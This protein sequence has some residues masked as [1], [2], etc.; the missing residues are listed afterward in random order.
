MYRTGDL[1]RYR[2]DGNIEFLGR[3]DHQVKVRGFRIELG[4]IEAQ[5]VDHAAVREAVVIARARSEASQ[6]Q[7]LIAYVTLLADVDASVLREH[8]AERLPDYMVP[9]A[10]VMLDALPLTPNGKLDRHALPD[11]HADAFALRPFEAPLGETES[12][13]ADLWAELLGLDR[14]GRQDNFFALGG[15]SLLAVTLI[16]RMRRIGLHANV[17]D[18][19]ATPVLS[20]L[21]AS[22]ERGAIPD[23]IVVPPNVIT[24]D[25]TALTPAMLP[26]IALTQADIDHIVGQVPGGLANVQDIYALA[27][28]QEGI[29]FHH[30]LTTEGDPYLQTARIAFDSRARLD[31]WLDALQRIIARHDILRTAFIHDGISTPAQV[32]CREAPVTI[33]EIEL[34]P[35]HGPAAD[36]LARLF[37]AR[38]QRLPLHQAPLLRLTIAKEHD[39]PRWLALLVWHHL[40]GDHVTLEVIQKEISALLEGRADALN[41]AQPFRD[42]V[43]QARLGATQQEHEAFFR[44]MLA[45]VSEPTLPFGF[46]DVHHDGSAVAEARVTLPAALNTRLRTQARELGVSLAS[47]CHLAW[48]RVLDAA[49]ASDGRIVFGTVLLGRMQA[50]VDQ[51]LGLLI[52]T[53]PIRL[54]VNDA[55]VVD[56]VRDTHRRL[57]ALLQHQHAPLALA[58]RCSGV[59]APAPLFSA[60]LNYRHNQAVA[61]EQY[62]FE[63]IELLGAEERTNYPLMLAVED[64]GE[65]LGL[66]AQ[67]LAPLSPDQLCGYMEQA[68]SSLVQALEQAPQTPVD[69]L[70]VLP[71]DTRQLLVQTWNDTAA[72]YPVELCIHQLF[73]QQ[74]ERTPDAIALVFDDQTLTYA[75]LNARANRLARRLLALGVE[76]EDRVALCVERG[77]G[78]VVSLLAILKAGGAYVPLDPA[79]PGERLTH[80]LTDSTP[81]LL[82]AD[83]TGREALGDTGTLS[84][85]DPNASLDESAGNPQTRLA[86]HHLAYVLF[87]SGSTGKPKGVMVEHREMLNFLCSMRDITS[88]SAADKLLAVTT[89][90]FDIAGLEL[91]LPLSTGACIV[92]ASRSDAADPLALQALIDAHAISFMQATPATWRMLLD[93]QWSGSAKLTAL[94]GGEA[95]SANLA[96]R[97]NEK[98]KA[99]W[100][101]YGPTETT[102]WSSCYRTGPEAHRSSTISVGRPIAN[103]RLYVLDAHYRL[104]PPGA[105]GEL[106][107]GGAGVARGYLNRPDLTA[108]RFLDV[109]F[110]ADARIYRTGDLARYRAD[111]NLEFLGRN[112]HQV[113]I[114]GFRIELGEIEAQLASHP[115]VREAVVIA[116]ARREATQDQQL[117]AY[118]TGL[119]DVDTNALREHV[120]ARLPDY[121]VP[122]AFV[123]LDALPLTPNGKLDRRALPDPQWQDLGAYVAPRTSLEHTLAQCFASVLGLERVSVFDNFFALGG[124]SLLATQLVSRLRQA[125]SIE[126]PLRTLFDAPTVASLAETLQ[127]ETGHV[128]AI[129]TLQAR[130]RPRHLPLSFAQ[131]RLWFLEQLN[132]GQSTYN[133]PVAVR[134]SGSLDVRSLET[135]LNALLERHESLR[136]S[137]VQQGGQAV[138]CIA[139]QLQIALPLV[140]LDTLATDAQ[141]AEVR[142]I[143]QAEATRAFDLQHGP[144]LRAQL[145]R[146][147]QDEHMLLFTMHHIISDGWSIGVLV[148]ELGACYKAMLH[149]EPLA[150]PRLVVQYADFTLWQ[151][152]WLAGAELDR[153]TQ[154]WC[155]QLAELAPLDLPTD[156]PR[157][158]R[159]S[160]RGATLPFSLSPDLSE[161]VNTLAHREGVTPYMVVLA[162]FQTLLA[163]LSGQSQVAVGSPI[164]N[165]THAQIEPLIGLFVNTLVLRADLSGEPCLR[166]LLA[167]V[168]DTTLAAYAHQDLPFEKLVEALAPVRD[169]SRTPLF[170]V[171]LVLQNAPLEALALPGLTLELL[172]PAEAGA[173]FDLTL[174]LTHTH[175]R[176][177]GSISYATDLFDKHTIVRFGERFTRL[178][179]QAL[180]RPDAP[181]HALELVLPEEH[182][183]FNQWN[184]TACAY[185]D[186]L[187]M[188]QLFEQQVRRTPDATALVFEDE[189][190]TYAELNARANRLAHRLIA[191]RVQPE[192]RVALCME[193]RIG[194]IVSLIATLKAGGAYMPL[195]PAYPGERLNH[196]LADAEPRLLIADA[197]GRDALG[198][199][200]PL[201]VLDLHAS[202]EEALSPAD[203]QAPVAPHNLAYVIYT[204]GSTGKPKGV[205]IEHR[206]AVNFLSWALNAFTSKE[207]SHTLFATSVNF[208][209][210]VYECFAPLTCGA[211]VHLVDNVL[212]LSRKPHDVSLVNTVPSAITSLLDAGASLASVK[213]INLAGEPLKLALMK[214]IFAETDIERLCNL[215]GPSETTT[216]STWIE[217]HKGD[218]VTETIGKPIGNTRV[219]LL[220]ARC[221]PV[222]LGT[223][224]EVYIGGAGV[225]RGYLN[226]PELTAERFLDDPFMPGERMYRTG[227]LARYRADGN[228]EFLGRNDHQVKVRGFRIELGEI[229]AQLV[230]HAAVREAVVIARARSEASQDQQLIAYVT[231]LADVDASV[232]REHL[233]ER[234]PDYM[235][236][237]AI[238]MLDALPLTP[239]GKLDRHALPDPHADAFALRPFE[240][241]LGETESSLADL[242]AELLGLD[243]VGRQD[244]FF[245]LGG[246]SLL[247]VTLIER[248]RRIGLHANVRD[249]FATPVLSTLAASIERGAIPDD[250]VVPPNVI[251]RDTT[252]LTPAMLPL[253]ALTQ[254]DIDHIVGQVPGGLANVQ[255]IYALAPLQE[256]ILFHHMLT[257]EGDPYLQTARIAFDS[258]AR[259][260]AWLDALQRIIARHDILRTAFIHDGISTPAQVVCREAPVTIDEIELDPAH[261]PAADQ[262]ARLFDARS[263]RLPLH[264]APLLRLTIAKEHDSPRWLALLVWHHLIG[265]H[266]T[267]EV[268]QKEISALLEGRADALN[269][270]Q[271]FRDLVAQARLGATQ[272]EHEAFF[273]DMLAD[274]SEPTL[275]FGFTDVHHD[276]SA[277]AEARVTLPAALNTR[278]RTQARELGVSLASLC[279]LAWARVLDAASASD[280]RIVF[281]TVLLGRMQ[282]GVDQALGLL[283]NTLPIRLDVNDASVVDSVRDTHRRLAALL[284]HQHAPLALAQRCSGVAA[285][286]PLFSALLNYRHNQAVAD[287]QYAFEGI[288]LL[289]AEERTNYPLMLAVED[290]GESLGLTAQTL[291]PLSPDQLCGY[292]EQALS[293]LVQALEQAPQ[294]PVDQLDVLPP[295]TRQL[296]VQTWNDTAAPYPVELCIHQLFEQQV[297]RTP[298]A[299]ALV[300]DDQTLT[301]AQ[302]NARANRL[303]RRLLA[304][305]VE[306]EDRVALCVER[307]IGMVVSL[308][309]ILKAGG[310]YVPL[311]PAYPGERLTHIL[312]DSTPRLLIADAT[313]REALGDTG[314]LSVLDPNASLD[315]S[316]GNPQTRLAPHHLAYVLFTSGSTG[317]P[318]GVMV[319]HREMLNFLCSMRDITS[320]SAADKLLAVTTIS[321]DIAGLELY[322]PLSTGAC[323]VLA[324]RSDAADPLALQALIDAHAISFMQATPATWRMLLDTQ[325]SGSAKLTALCGGEALSANLAARLNEKVKALW[326]LY[327]PTETTVWS[328][329]YR[330]G[331]E[332]HRSSTISVGRPIANT[333]LY[334][335]DAHYRLVP[336][337]AVGE[338]YI[339]GAGVAR[340]YLNRPDLTAERFLDDPFIA[341]ARIYRTGD[342]ARY[343]ADGNL[344]FLGRNDH[345]VKIRG[346]RIELGEIEAQLASHP[347][348]REAVVIARARREATQ[349]QQLIAYVTGLA[350]V[351]TNALREHVSARLPDYMVPS[352]FVTLDALPLTPNG[353]LDRR[354][355][356]D[357][358][359]QDLGAY[360]APRTSLEHTLAQ[361]FASV[362][363]LE[364]VSVFDNFFALGGHSLLAVQL[365]ASIHAKLGQDISIRVLFNAPSVAEL[366]NQLNAAPS[367]NEFDPI[368]PIRTPGDG[369]PLFCIHPVGGLAWSYAGLAKII[370]GDRP[371]YAVQTPALKHPGYGPASIAEMAADYIARI[372]TIQPHGPY[373]LLGWSFGGLL[374][375]EMATQLQSLGEKVGELVL[376]DSRL[377]DGLAAPEVDECAL[378]AATFPSMS[379]DLMLTLQAMRSTNERVVALR[380][381]RLIPAY[382]TDD[383][384]TTLIGTTQRNMQ[385][386]SMFTPKSFHGDIVYFTA[387]RSEAPGQPRRIAQWRDC[388]NGSIANYDIDCMH[389]EMCLPSSL[390]MIGQNLASM[391]VIGASAK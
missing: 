357:P 262:L 20:T 322:L 334:V 247:A 220:D 84:V 188:H 341:D 69:Q 321:F 46:T 16:E 254:A 121:M 390:A 391:N 108:E 100:N 313:G 204:S 248:M 311:D 184:D 123:T 191:L 235:V 161:R 201:T 272:Q 36:Q 34:D 142:R 288:E 90:S 299:I 22:I 319:E 3:N 330:T 285:P 129:P 192:D 238:V 365:M 130:T 366:A 358:Q 221:K 240:A 297:E 96:A 177:T 2:A 234:L 92:L 93:T 12:S 277:V 304:L 333:R 360:V 115:A 52:N 77:I 40:I 4:E 141:A 300:F 339:G 138:Q 187:C 144:L 200:G 328:S 63:G 199:T 363:G 318:K 51:A 124:H 91:Y 79:Y 113:K 261:G 375:Y 159:I 310:A 74:V 352:A 67:T 45:D 83:A 249:L 236:P 233:A 158:A 231:L 175:D 239:N 59:A 350:D 213:T 281:G 19:F 230:D 302:L 211:T 210:S 351:D 273:R 329:C 308:L 216:Y 253:I 387:T 137:F 76:P 362:L 361:C 61:D 140:E 270:A 215:Y 148:R 27:P 242:W 181:L 315:E 26:L 29:L 1:A 18:L 207:L 195:D 57:A 258:R 163:R 189:S 14:V 139:A 269:V 294:T 202:D 218:R 7:Q 156:R 229:E 307:G 134:L 21:A 289:G 136:T 47:L 316:A 280:G 384:I 344:E 257:T 381:H 169:M 378:F 293:S 287:E 325:W 38:S 284:Q 49:S 301:Y 42:L 55:S 217:M 185:P 24:R 359:W 296:L 170:Q 37:D 347:A 173:K 370:D 374:A 60:L 265:D 150:L 64:N 166:E 206:N 224:G 324:S 99:L 282:A 336:P 68:L 278:L 33:D 286:A 312:T 28:L 81:R 117:I 172:P 227:D 85:L 122:S 35:A 178:L 251:T 203:P 147:A 320:M 160:G 135:A 267:L 243:R 244:N 82:I 53:L 372:R 364:R 128:S 382:I 183:L 376:L 151:R 279:H 214:R 157:P 266:V 338:L 190:L 340:G 65:S 125:L 314:T 54:D 193:R 112:D 223:V 41:V 44:D 106:Y 180:A 8:L 109:P 167:Q 31:A 276:G 371:I 145:L 355:L 25:T 154:Y 146:L 377:P 246:H 75:Q 153:Q 182:A 165:R 9:S 379:P 131:E 127:Q 349:D 368:L 237:S 263:Q 56:S 250:I 66:T 88:M 11:P 290:N 389:T 275:P 168:R 32:V 107:I 179:D 367:N 345:Q 197:V 260:D 58:Q 152:D 17:R 222:P 186:H 95:L 174:N 126:L 103:T 155:T 209:L 353:K 205:A 369:A 226:R 13:L 87:T 111:G 116:R 208:D 143:T 70:D 110:I 295:D 62:A 292:M 43:A 6:D 114:R 86:P 383:H 219:Y 198:D 388:V 23:D 48:A 89:I 30:M 271:P 5:L 264:Q 268:I 101:L 132:P 342:L 78:M 71:P 10:I 317:K 15:H 335:L 306:P 176:F 309:A 337:G 228:I 97:L 255:D 323:I 94:C 133:I 105:V 256:G 119:A 194:M 149:D 196:I 343:R 72:P 305:G 232:L 241:P 331:P 259:L 274:V 356:P 73:E 164:A 283:I 225:A 332:A 212:A 291:A 162:A 298:D 386:Q 39:S 80:I 171:M 104:V 102:V 120:S 373:H 50:G 385:L 346:F 327:G 380:E 326:N 98:V 348:V 354:A 118:V 245:A 252:A 303:A